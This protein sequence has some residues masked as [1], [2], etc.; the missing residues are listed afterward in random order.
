LIFNL[1]SRLLVKVGDGERHVFDRGRLMYTEVAEIE[2]VTGLA[3]P[4]WLDQLAA[5]K[6]TAVAGLLHILRKRDGQPSDFGSMQFNVADLDVIPLHDDG[7]EFTPAEV[8]EDVQRRVA[9]AQQPE[10][11]G[12]TLAAGDAAVQ[13][14]VTP[15]TTGIS[16]S[17]LNGSGSGRGNGSGS[18]GRISPSARRTSTSS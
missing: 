11:A 10:D 6:I 13:P 5:Y 1:Y 18:R 4:E 15:V 7:T 8:V 14:E 12:P 17:S 16:P 3:Y 9:E 2:K